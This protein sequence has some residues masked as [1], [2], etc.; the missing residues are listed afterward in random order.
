M[1]QRATTQFSEETTMTSNQHSVQINIAFK[2]LEATEPLKKYAT[3]KLSHAI[4]KFLHQDAEG[5]LVLRV[6]KT[7]QRAELNLHAN[8][9]SFNVSEE[10]DDLYKT[11]DALSDSIAAQLRKHK[12]K[13]KSH[14]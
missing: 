10:S 8:G 2:N 1:W 6:E 13:L 4:S 5:N 9:S 12:E 14:H 3:E 7:R 11:I